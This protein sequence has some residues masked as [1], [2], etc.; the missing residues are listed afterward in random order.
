MPELPE[1]ETI[2]ND[3]EKLIKGAEILDIKATYSEIIKGIDFA[4]F[5]EQIIGSKI[6]D[7]KRRAKSL[8]FQISRQGSVAGSQEK[9]LLVHLKMTG[10]FIVTDSKREVD[11]KG[12]WVE[13]G[14]VFGDEKN[15]YIRIQFFLNNGKQIAFSDLRK[16]A[17][18]KLVNKKE[19]ED[20]LGEYG[21]EPLEKDFTAKKLGGLLKDK[22][23]PIKKVLM[24]QKVIA[25]IGNIYADEVL[26]DSRISPKRPA[27]QVS[28][29]EVKNLFHSIQKILKKALELRGTSTSD[30]RDAS[31]EKGSYGDIRMVYRRTGEKCPATCGGKIVRITLGGRGTHYCP[32]C[33]K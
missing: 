17:Y 21:P 22:K 32:K 10:H 30:Y 29:E 14:Q 3:L 5:K 16:F 27:N 18:I 28:E 31:G 13:K 33:Q 1:V 6:T 8:I 20:F 24:D 25:G 15:Q 12:A 7:V 9:Y 19:L 4:S 23:G 26:F 2:K 11:S